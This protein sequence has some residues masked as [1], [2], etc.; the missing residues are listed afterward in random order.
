M[1]RKVRSQSGDDRLRL[2]AA[3]R[4]GFSAFTPGR[5][6]AVAAGL[7]A[8]GVL[9]ASRSLHHTDGPRGTGRQRTVRTTR[10]TWST[11]EF[12]DTCQSRL[13]AARAEV[14]LHPGDG[15]AHLRLAILE[16][17]H[18]FLL[19]VVASETTPDPNAADA[20]RQEFVRR[21]PAG[22]MAAVDRS[23]AAALQR[24]LDTSARRQAVRLL[25]DVR[26]IRGDARGEVLA[27]EEATRLAPA[28]A[29]LWA[30][31]A[32][33]HARARQFSRAEA[34]MSQ[35]QRLGQQCN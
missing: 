26:A 11:R 10:R 2:R 24:S 6:R 16:L 21:D 14:A 23:A 31:R 28:D 20:R 22:A 27:L 15:G 35:A 8:L 29:G 13:V 33:A 1:R 3:E 25:A 7:I 34:A 5:R 9:V 17:R 19:A 32:A 18:A 12:L 30:R 4:R